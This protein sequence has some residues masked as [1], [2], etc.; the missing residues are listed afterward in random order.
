MFLVKEEVG[1]DKMYVM[2]TSNMERT[3]KE[4]GTSEE[5]LNGLLECL[6]AL[7]LSER[8][9][10]EEI[11]TSLKHEGGEDWAVGEMLERI[12][13]FLGNTGAFVTGKDGENMEKSNIKIIIETE[14]GKHTLKSEYG[15]NGVT[16]IAPKELRSMAVNWLDGIETQ[17]NNPLTGIKDDDFMDFIT[18]GC[19]YNSPRKV[20]LT[21]GSP[22]VKVIPIE[23]LNDL[24]NR[25][26]SGRGC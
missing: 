25:Q 11:V 26:R 24:V 9:R 1:V 3:I 8:T 14:D 13:H 15:L 16:N 18:G 4:N 20:D 10:L 2:P 21:K 19:G 12:I 7:K 6:S 22:G 23:S 5:L 17:D